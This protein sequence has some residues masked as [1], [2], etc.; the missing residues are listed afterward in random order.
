MAMNATRLTTAA[1]CLALAVG[2]G[3]TSFW[4]FTAGRGFLNWLG[5]SYVGAVAVGAL[6]YGGWALFGALFP[7]GKQPQGSMAGWTPKAPSHA[8][9]DD[10]QDEV[11]RRRSAGRGQ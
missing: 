4:L 5:G 1:L 8:E 10:T 6:L 3:L 2:A 11:V 9:A 7:D